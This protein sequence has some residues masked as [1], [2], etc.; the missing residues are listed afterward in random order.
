[1]PKYVISVEESTFTTTSVTADSLAQA[2]E[3]TIMQHGRILS[4]NVVEREVVAAAVDGLEL[5]GETIS[6]A[7]EL[8][9]I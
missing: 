4:L 6:A 1:M 3:R 5:D 9:E 7:R 2:L 8:A